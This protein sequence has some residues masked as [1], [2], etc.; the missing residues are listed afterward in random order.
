MCLDAA[1]ANANANANAHA[2]ASPSTSNNVICLHVTA[3]KRQKSRRETKKLQE[4][5]TEEVREAE[6]LAREWGKY[7]KVVDL[8]RSQVSGWCKTD[9]TICNSM[10]LYCSRYPV[11]LCEQ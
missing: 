2:N 5:L 3:S 1:N 7:S 10:L 9:D 8:E 4:K 6:E 11:Q